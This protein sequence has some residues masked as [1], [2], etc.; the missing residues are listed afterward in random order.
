MEFRKIALGCAVALS[1][2]LL[3]FPALASNVSIF[4][5]TEGAP[6][7]TVS[8]DIDVTKVTSTAEFLH[9][10]GTLHIPFG[11]GR[12]QNANGANDQSFLMLEPDGSLSDFI[13]FVTGASRPG[14]NDFLED[15]VIDF[16]SDPAIPAGVDGAR[17]FED[18]TLQAMPFNTSGLTG[19]SFF[20]ISVQSDVVADV[21]EPS[22]LALLGLALAGLGL[23]RRKQAG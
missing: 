10:E 11:N 9:I 19:G 18:G 3:T 16:Y 17:V 12:I 2:G 21:P 7:F 22:V 5:L 23:M 6:T 1:A 15:F 8:A 20:G 14:P 13:H 4:D